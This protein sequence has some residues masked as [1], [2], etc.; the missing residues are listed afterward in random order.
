MFVLAS[1]AFLFKDLGKGPS[2]AEQSTAERIPSPSDLNLKQINTGTRSRD[3]KEPT[4]L[5]SPSENERRAC[6]LPHRK[7]S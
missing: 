1:L 2:N 5:S 4:T 7:Q 3:H 6:T